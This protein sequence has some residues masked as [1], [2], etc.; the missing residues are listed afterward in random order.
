VIFL[1]KKLMEMPHTDNFFMKHLLI[2]LLIS[3]KKLVTHAPFHGNIN[4]TSVI[5]IEQDFLEKFSN[6]KSMKSSNLSNLNQIQADFIT[7]KYRLTYH[8]LNMISIREWLNQR[9]AKLSEGSK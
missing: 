4:H 6:R 9:Q 7:Y 1:K 2:G 3:Y 5:G 8:H